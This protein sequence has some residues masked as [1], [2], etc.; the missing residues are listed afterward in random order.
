M[1]LVD[2]QALYKS[3]DQNQLSSLYFLFGEEPYLLRQAVQRLTTQ[4]LADGLKDFNYDTYYANDCDI[5]QVR[6][7]VETLPMMAT[8]RVVVLHETDSLN[9]REWAI[10]EPVISTPVESTI[11]ILTASK[12][13]KRKKA[14]KTLLDNSV[15]VE[16]RKPFENQ[17]PAWIQYICRNHGLTISNDAQQLL[18]R[19][20]GSQLGE[21]DSEI[22]KL[23]SF[24]GDRNRIELEDVAQCVS[25]SREENVFDLTTALANGDRLRSL[26]HLVHLLDQG[27]SEIGIVSLIARHVRILLLIKQGLDIGLSGVKLASH[28]QVPPYYVQ[29]YVQQSRH[30]TMRKL[31][32]VLLVLS[33]TDKALK[34]SPL[35]SHIWLENLI[36]KSCSLVAEHA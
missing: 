34:S 9:E 11:F 31:Q 2:S 7:T 26:S 28:A 13:D 35:S 19:L 24:L 18:H 5:S 1:P 17:I 27:Q 29:E 3:L 25:R 22:Q 23:R 30:W 21:M 6:D 10:L 33:E 14:M 12:V 15:A 8:T 32:S 20:I 16:F 4:A 36:M